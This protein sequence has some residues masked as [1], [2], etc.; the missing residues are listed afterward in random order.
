MLPSAHLCCGEYF[1]PQLKH[2][3]LRRRSSQSCLERWRVLG[4][5]EGGKGLSGT[6]VKED[7][8]GRDSPIAEVGLTGD[9]L[10]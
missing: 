9:G 2:N 5:R 7:P 10:K 1:N 6:R 8:V 4:V 3:P